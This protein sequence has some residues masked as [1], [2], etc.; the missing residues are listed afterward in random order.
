MYV[1]IDG[2]EYLEEYSI[3]GLGDP[4]GGMVSFTDA[5]DGAIAVLTLMRIL[6]LTQEVVYPVY[7]AFPAKSHENALDKL[8]WITQQMEEELIRA[9]KIP[10]DGDIGDGGVLL[11][12]PSPGDTIV[13][14]DEGTGFDNAPGEDSFLSWVNRAEAAASDAAL[15]ELQSYDWAMEDEGVPVDDGIHPEGYSAYHWAQQAA[16]GGIIDITSADTDMMQITTPL[17]RYREITPVVGTPGGMVKLDGNGV[18]PIELMPIQGNMRFL[19]LIEGHDRCPKYQY[20]IPDETA[21]VDP[22]TRNPSE[23]IPSIT[24]LAGDWFAISRCDEG[25]LLNQM[26]LID[27]NTQLYAIQDVSD[28]DAVVYLDG[29]GGM[30]AIGWYLIQDFVSSDE[31]MADDVLFDDTNTTVKG[32]NVQLFNQ[33]MD[34]SVVGKLDL[35]GGNMVGELSLGNN[36]NVVGFGTVPGSSAVLSGVNG[37]D[38]VVYGLSDFTSPVVQLYQGGEVAVQ[39]ANDVVTFNKTPRY[40]TDPVDP[41]DLANKQYVDEAGANMWVD[42]VDHI[43]PADNSGIL[44]QDASVSGHSMEIISSWDEWTA[45]LATNQTAVRVDVGGFGEE[46]ENHGGDFI[47]I[48]I[49]GSVKVPANSALL[50]HAAGVAGFAST[51]THQNFAVGGYFVGHVRAAGPSP[52]LRTQAWGVNPLA[53][54]HGFDNAVIYGA[55]VNTNCDHVNTWVHGV[56]VI[57]GSTA[58]AIVSRAFEVGHLGTFAVPKIPWQEGL[59]IQDGAA[60]KGVYLGLRHHGGDITESVSNNICFP[61]RAADGST[62]EIGILSSPT[63][64]LWFVNIPEQELLASFDTGGPCHLFYDG[65]TRLQ[66]VATGI[67]VDGDITCQGRLRGP[68]GGQGPYFQARSTSHVISFDY[69]SPDL[70]IYAEDTI[71]KTFVIQHPTKEEKC[72]V[73]GTL[74]GPEAAVYYRGVAQVTM[75]VVQIQLPEY[76]TALT[77]DE[78]IT[79]QLTNVNGFDRLTVVESLGKQVHEGK[80]VIAAEDKTSFQKFNWEVKAV[81]RDVDRLVVEPNKADIDIAGDGPYTYIKAKK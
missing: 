63:G 10:I 48:G 58:T 56:T 24:F 69:V 27:P 18:I 80:F 77:N 64:A 74:E 26:N 51:V 66:T 34:A 35:A 33:A 30:S 49:S 37:G 57:G 32:V 75:G 36:I 8:T 46:G 53:W 16:E 12:A 71:V 22:D 25:P 28:G 61:S 78:D 7:G 6:P 3:T 38:V 13:W 62:D 19:S 45:P 31:V 15:S 72:L 40:A 76:F 44:L 14:N 1:Y 81:R 20:E 59:H 9:I 43:A 70:H 60:V 11:P 2:E 42:N 50:H 17:D 47:M 65:S 55:E 29:A 39:I 4:I 21:C 5:P 68:A 67:N 52:T 79:I 23:R 54:D 73:H 41:A